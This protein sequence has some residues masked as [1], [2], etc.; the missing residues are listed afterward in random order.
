[1]VKLLL[2]LLLTS[3]GTD[4]NDFYYNHIV[5]PK[6]PRKQH[7]IDKE[8]ITYT[9]Y[10]EKLYNTKIIDI[11]INFAIIDKKE[12]GHCKFHIYTSKYIYKEI[13]IN[14]LYWH[15]LSKLQRVY[16]IFHELGHCHFNKGHNINLINLGIYK[17]VPQSIMFPEDFG[18]KP[19]FKIYF[20]YYVKELQK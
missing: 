11:P 17:K 14:S 19:V 9:L 8:F 10:F 18:S 5:S 13:F 1:M 6:D 7:G 16:L 4:F 20:K 3:C 15:K 12:L 2:F